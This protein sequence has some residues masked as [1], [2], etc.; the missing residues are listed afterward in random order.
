MIH[1]IV[2]APRWTVPHERPD[3]ETA[4][5]KLKALTKDS[6]RAVNPCYVWK[7][8][9]DTGNTYMHLIHSEGSLVDFR[10]MVP[11]A[12][13]ILE[14]IV[15]DTQLVSLRSEYDKKLATMEAR[16]KQQLDAIFA[17]LRGASQDALREASLR[18][19]EDVVTSGMIEKLPER[20]SEL[21]DQSVTAAFQRAR[22]TA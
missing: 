11:S 21:I 19:L 1:K 17:A 18:L 12:S 13:L 6:Y 20:L 14:K 16:H 15:V 4:Q 2:E 9:G 7:R 10:S 3:Y 5:A 22:D 8:I